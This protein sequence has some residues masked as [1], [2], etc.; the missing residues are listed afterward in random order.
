MAAVAASGMFLAAGCKQE[1]SPGRDDKASEPAAAK[2]PAA[3]SD[4]TAPVASA[5]PPTTPA[6]A[7]PSP[8]ATV[9]SE[10]PPVKLDDRPTE[11]RLY[12]DRIEASSFL[13]TDWNRF[14]ENYHPNYLMDGDPATAWVEG[15]DSSGKGEWVRVH[16]SPVEGVTHVR[17][18]LQDGYHKSKSLHQKNARARQITITALP[19]GQRHQA[20]LADDMSW[21]EIAF[22]VPAGR[23]DALELAIDEVYEGSKYTD[24][25]L[26]ELEVYLTGLTVENPAFEKAK[27]DEI[28]GW[29]K[30]R[31]AAAALFG[32]RK[33]AALP[34]LPGYRVV[35]GEP[36]AAAA[37]DDDF[38]ASLTALASAVPAAAEVAGRA[39]AAIGKEFS[40]WRPVQVVARPPLALPAVDGLYE[41][42]SLE[43][44]FEPRTD[45][46]MLPSSSQGVLLASRTLS[47]FD[48]QEKRDPRKRTDCKEGKTWFMRPPRGEGGGAGAAGPLPA[49]LLTV[50]CVVEETREGQA[51]YTVWQLLEF[52]S[53]GNLVL[54]VGPQQ[55]QWLEWRAEAAASGGAV[56]AGGL[57]IARAGQPTQKLVDARVAAKD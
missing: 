48:T 35:D 55:V 32:T 8:T 1:S 5:T 50:R 20:S 44:V 18:R 47:L 12:S 53:Q 17:L 22:D 10:A 26:S 27:L 49:E 24:L 7:K 15:A 52:D 57:R 41:P 38:S 4:P 42:G 40:G 46:F 16:L 21:Q 43:L 34:I 54:M 19:G 51:S 39:S 23:V 31:L 56:L 33:A 25:C 28:L 13:W 11:R 3:N 45:A 14:Q 29:K 9:V 30:N 2:A 36:A 6:D 37:G